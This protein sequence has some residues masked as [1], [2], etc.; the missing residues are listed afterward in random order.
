[1][2]ATGEERVQPVGWSPAC[3]VSW[4]TGLWVSHIAVLGDGDFD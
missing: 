1:M 3:S 4:R 2:K